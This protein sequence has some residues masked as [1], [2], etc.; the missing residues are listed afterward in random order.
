MGT[1]ASREE[2]Q[3]SAVRLET[4]DVLGE[5]FSGEVLAARVDGDS[6]G[7]GKFAGNT[8]F[9]EIDRRVNEGPDSSSPAH[10]VFLPSAR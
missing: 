4:G 10:D 6:N 8:G 3:T 2:D 7:G 9:L 1:S 5:R